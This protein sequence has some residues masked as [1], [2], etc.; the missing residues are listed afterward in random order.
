MSQRGFGMRWAG[1]QEFAEFMAE[2]DRKMGGVMKAV[3][4]AR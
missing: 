3:G 4:L 2:E 1:P